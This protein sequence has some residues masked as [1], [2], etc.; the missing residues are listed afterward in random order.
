MAGKKGMKGERLGGARPNAGRPLEA[1]TLRLGQT[2]I[3]WT[4]TDEGNPVGLAQTWTVTEVTRQHFRY[5]TETGDNVRMD[6]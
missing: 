6:R 2:V 4:T 1:G 3:V 5:V